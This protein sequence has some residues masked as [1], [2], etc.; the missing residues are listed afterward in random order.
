MADHYFSDLYQITTL[1]DPIISTSP[2]HHSRGNPYYEIWFTNRNSKK[3]IMTEVVTT[4]ENFNK[5]GWKEIIS[6]HQEFGN[7]V[8]YSFK[9]KLKN[10]RIPQGRQGH[11]TP[12]ALYPHYKGDRINGD[13]QPYVYGVVQIDVKLNHQDKNHKRIIKENEFFN[14]E[15]ETDIEAKE[16]IKPYDEN[17]RYEHG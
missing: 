17:A 15:V 1:S 6:Y 5:N 16:I 2:N 14:W 10:H 3:R 12:F 11:L 8:V 9:D 7:V 13:S 4:Y